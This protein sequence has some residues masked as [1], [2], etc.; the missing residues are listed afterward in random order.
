MKT[1]AKFL[2]SAKAPSGVRPVKIAIIDDGIN[3]ALDIFNNRIHGGE[4]FHKLSELSGRRGSYYVPSGM[5][6]SLMAQLICEVCPNVRL[7]IGQLEA[8]PG[9][10]GR[11]TFTAESAAEVRHPEDPQGRRELT[12]VRPLTGR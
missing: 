2:R 6:G 4:S 1:F 8:L 5:H 12:R 7:Y 3:T 10:D 11:R 9:Q